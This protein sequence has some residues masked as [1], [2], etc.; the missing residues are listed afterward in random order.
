MKITV[1]DIGTYTFGTC[2]ICTYVFKARPSQLKKY[3]IKNK[4]D[5]CAESVYIRW[6]RNDK[7]KSIHVICN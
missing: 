5:S 7:L 3:G 1:N 4:S 6:S 2:K